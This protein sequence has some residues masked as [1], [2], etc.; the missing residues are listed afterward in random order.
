M[1]NNC[2]VGALFG[3]PPSP[4]DFPPAL[5]SLSICIVI[6]IASLNKKLTLSEERHNHLSRQAGAEFLFQLKQRQHSTSVLRR[7]WL[8]TS[9]M[10]HSVNGD[11]TRWHRVKT[12]PCLL[13]R[14]NIGNPYMWSR[15]SYNFGTCFSLS[16]A[17]VLWR[18][19]AVRPAQPI[20][21]LK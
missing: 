4:T 15:N 20:N 19:T 21:M 11:V 9:Y 13:L 7:K 10:L 2:K 16:S 6:L 12:G 17:E 14:S 5:S 3:C 1:R 18:F 8:G